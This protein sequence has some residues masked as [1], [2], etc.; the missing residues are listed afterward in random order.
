ME[1][2][3]DFVGMYVLFYRRYKEIPV[4][5][6]SSSTTSDQHGVACIG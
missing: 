4:R 1:T 2:G 5:K 3:E 6:S